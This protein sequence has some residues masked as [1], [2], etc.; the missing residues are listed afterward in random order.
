VQYD[1]AE[2][3]L[4]EMEK[5]DFVVTLPSNS[6]MQAHAANRGHNYVVKQASPINLT[7]PTLNFTSRWEVALTTL[8]YTN[9]FYQLRE[10]VTIFAVIIVPG[11]EYIHIKSPLGKP[12]QLDVDFDDD[13]PAI[14]ALSES[15]RRILKPFIKNDT[16]KDETWFVVFGKFVV[17]A[18]EYK[19]P[20]ELARRVAKEFSIVFNIPRYQHECKWSELGLAADFASLQRASWKPLVR[21]A[22]YNQH[23]RDRMALLWTMAGRVDSGSITS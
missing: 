20:M 5:S 9:Q 11:L 16:N 15:E 12:I 19:T 13:M 14:K 10:D 2:I 22:E 23:H 1:N 21:R 7:G 17:P 18:G 8:Q 6:N 3:N 4:C